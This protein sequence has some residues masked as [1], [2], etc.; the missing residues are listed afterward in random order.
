MRG[1]AER[2]GS[3][4]RRAAGAAAVLLV[5]AMGCGPSAEQVATCARAREARSGELE[6]ALERWRDAAGLDSDLA[7]GLESAAAAPDPRAAAPGTNGD[8][9]ALRAL[10]AAL[11]QRAEQTRGGLPQLDTA[12]AAARAPGRLDLGAL[13]EANAAVAAADREVVARAETAGLVS[14]NRF[15]LPATDLDIAESEISIGCR[16]VEGWP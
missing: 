7:T 16:T 6:Q 8:P 14:V 15:A 2:Q 11:Q 12:I 4:V 9:A 1:V 10:A 13:R 3:A 5:L